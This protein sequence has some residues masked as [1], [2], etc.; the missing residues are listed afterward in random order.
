[1][2]VPCIYFEIEGVRYS[3]QEILFWVEKRIF[4]VRQ[5]IRQRIVNSGH[6]VFGP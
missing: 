4:D 5:E 1:M 6:L 3:T 2:E